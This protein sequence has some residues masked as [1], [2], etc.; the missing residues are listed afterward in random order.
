M[1]RRTNK[2]AQVPEDRAAGKLLGPHDHDVPVLTVRDVEGN[3]T[4]V[5]FGYACHS[6]VLSFYKWSGDYPGFAQ[7]AFEEQHPGCQAMFF[8]GCGAD[9]NPP[10][11]PDEN[12][13]QSKARP[14]HGFPYDLKRFAGSGGFSVTSL[15]MND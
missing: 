1:N 14:R 11:R 8:A 4:T 3:L 10:D 13:F 7:I 12:P 9:Q 15:K 2:E 5:V 6:T